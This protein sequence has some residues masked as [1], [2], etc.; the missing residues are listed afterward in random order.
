MHKALK[1]RD[2]VDWCVKKEKEDI[3]I[4]DDVDA[5]IQRREDYI[6]KVWRKT[7]YSHQKKYSKKSINRTKITWKQK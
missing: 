5:S 7:D 6:K 1:R 3:G 2:D 4:E